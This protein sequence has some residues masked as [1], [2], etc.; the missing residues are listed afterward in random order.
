MKA[1]DM[2]L[3]NSSQNVTTVSRPQRQ[4]IL[5]A[6]SAN[7][8]PNHYG[9]PLLLLLAAPALICWVLWYPQAYV[10][11]L[12]DVFLIDALM[13]RLGVNGFAA[14]LAVTTGVAWLGAVGTAALLGLGRLTVDIVPNQR[15]YAVERLGMATVFVTVSASLA[16][17]ALSRTVSLGIVPQLPRGP[18]QW[19]AFVPFIGA[20]VMGGRDYRLL[21]PLSLRL[22][23]AAY[24]TLCF[25][26]CFLRCWA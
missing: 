16:L 6:L 8:N 26:A 13:N 21:S 2:Q 15:F 11:G 23:Y 19:F 20:V 12:G 18:I 1:I 7:E 4:Q 3:S 22:Q 24:F 10:F 9:W 25:A 5:D 14:W 17:Y